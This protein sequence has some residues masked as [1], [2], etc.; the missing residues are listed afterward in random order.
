MGA[1]LVSDAGVIES[2]SIGGD[3]GTNLSSELGMVG[4]RRDL[5]CAVARRRIWATWI[6]AFLIVEPKVSGE[7]FSVFDFRILNIL[8]A[9]L[10]EVV[11]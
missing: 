1:T 6:N 11:V 9:V 2:D 10:S 3:V 8:S 5:G 7:F 4:G